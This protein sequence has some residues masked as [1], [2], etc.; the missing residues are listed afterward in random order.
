MHQVFNY[1]GPQQYGHQQ[2]ELSQHDL[3]EISQNPLQNDLSM[4][5]KQD[6]MQMN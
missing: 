3:E 5:E 1:N 6:L 4:A 2:Q